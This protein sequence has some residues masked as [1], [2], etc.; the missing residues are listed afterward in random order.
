MN[1]R[2]YRSLFCNFPWKYFFSMLWI[3]ISV[4]FIAYGVAYAAGIWASP[5][6]IA[7]GITAQYISLVIVNGNP[8]ISYYDSTT[9][10][11]MYIR[12]D[13]PDGKTWTPSSV[14]PVV[15]GGDVGQYASMAI[16]NGFPAIS[17]YDAAGDLKYVRALDATGTFP[18]GTPKTVDSVGNVGQYTSLAVVGGKPAISYHDV[19]NDSL[20]YIQA[21]DVNGDSWPASSVTVDNSL[22]VGQYTS[23][24]VVNGNPAIS[25]QEV[26]L[27]NMKYVRA[28]DVNGSAWLTPITL[29]TSNY[30]GSYTSLAVVDGLP[31][32]SYYDGNVGGGLKFIRATE[33]TGMILPW[34]TPLTVDSNLTGDVGR[35]TSLVV[36]SGNPAISYYDVD[37]GNLKYVRALNMDGSLWNTPAI[38]DDGGGADVGRYSSMAIVS[39]NPAVSYSGSLLFVRSENPTSLTLSRLDARSMPFS[40][41]LALIGLAVAGFVKLLF[42]RKFLNK[43]RL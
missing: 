21:N 2:P 12:A 34:N 30:D 17:Y 1:T 16:V 3:A 28:S 23:L 29:S 11:L 6:P 19:T 31:A 10:H 40:A 35:Y 4:F 18:W 33:A 27:G 9:H 37:N 36:V 43:D 41:S 13:D 22:G 39:G 42:Y 24:A 5:I 14:V 20:K 26:I 7:E 25:Y 8:A 15:T 38:L 32:V